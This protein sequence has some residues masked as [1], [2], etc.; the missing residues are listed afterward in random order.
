MRSD[1]K[2]KCWQEV[3]SS[4]RVWSG[5]GSLHCGVGPVGGRASSPPT[6]QAPLRLSRLESTTQGSRGAAGPRGWRARAPAGTISLAARG[7]LRVPGGLSQTE[8]VRLKSWKERED[9]GRHQ[10]NLVRALGEQSDSWAEEMGRKGR[11]ACG[12]SLRGRTRNSVLFMLTGGWWWLWGTRCYKKID[13]HSRGSMWMHMAFL[14]FIWK[15]MTYCE[16]VS[17]RNLTSS[18]SHPTGLS[19][20]SVWALESVFPFH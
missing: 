8:L 10:W 20:A 14:A 9:G 17:M 6:R 5:W 4:V 7:R 2:Q 13:T 16:D 12:F 1:L 11:R 18:P 15:Q 3:S 19:R